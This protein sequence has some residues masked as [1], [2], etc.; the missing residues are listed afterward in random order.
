AQGFWNFS[1][2]IHESGVIGHA[3]G[4]GMALDVKDANGVGLAVVH[5]G[6]VGPNLPF[7]HD[8]DSWSD[9]GFDQRIIDLWPAIV[10]AQ[11]SAGLNVTTDAIHIFDAVLAALGVVAVAVLA[12]AGAGSGHV[13]CEESPTVQRSEDGTGVDLVWKCYPK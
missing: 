10:S 3:Y 7:G 12:D 8:D 13:Q 6:S 9:T 4:F 2:S 1:G 11:S 5:S